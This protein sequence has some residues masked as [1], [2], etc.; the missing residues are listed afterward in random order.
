MGVSDNFVGLIQR[1]GESFIRDN[2]YMVDRALIAKALKNVDP[3]YQDK[4]FRNMTGDGVAAVKEMMTSLGDISVE[5]IE[6]AQQE[7]MTLASQVI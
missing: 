2:I 3:Q 1:T 6:A 5:V 4:I 7:I